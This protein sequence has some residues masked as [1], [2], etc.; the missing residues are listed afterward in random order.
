MFRAE[1]LR[2]LIGGVLINKELAREETQLQTTVGELIVRILILSYNNSS[3]GFAKS[4]LDQD[5][6]TLYCLRLEYQELI[7]LID[8]IE[9]NSRSR[10]CRQLRLMRDLFSRN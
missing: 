5:L 10:T 7:G 4:T 1:V 2:V 6:L 9:E 3:Y 8:L